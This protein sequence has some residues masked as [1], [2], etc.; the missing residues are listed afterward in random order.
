MSRSRYARRVLAGAALMMA[1][2]VP[3][4]RAQTI[5]TAPTG[6]AQS[7]SAN[8][9]TLMF[10]WFNADYERRLTP[11]TTWGASGAFTSIDDFGYKNVNATFKYYPRAAMDGFFIG[12]RTG[13]YHVTGLSES[14]NFYGAGFELGYNWLLGR[15]EN[16]V[17]GIGAGVTRLFG[18]ELAG[19]SLAFPTIRLVNVGYRF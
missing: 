5:D 11:N 18:G 4:A 3:C 6:P 9:F 15:K 12:G 1:T 19:A 8:P 7:L 14:A 17:V 10:K 13:L 16:V 2:V